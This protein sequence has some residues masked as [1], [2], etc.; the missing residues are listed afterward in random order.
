MDTADDERLASRASSSFAQPADVLTVAR[1]RADFDVGLWLAYGVLM[2]SAAS[3]IDRLDDAS[4]RGEEDFGS[5]SPFS[6]YI[7]MAGAAERA[8]GNACAYIWTCAVTRRIR[9]AR[10]AKENRCTGRAR[11]PELRTVYVG[12]RRAM[13][14]QLR[15]HLQPRE[16]EEA[17]PSGTMIWIWM[18]E[19][20]SVEPWC[21]R[22]TLVSRIWAIPRFIGSKSYLVQ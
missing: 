10:G 7:Y 1:L 18:E 5:V 19:Q 15:H 17:R 9:S 16:L 8:A 21:V 11:T 3:L 14:H 22:R 4:T 13:V 2:I 12:Q 6:A 20:K